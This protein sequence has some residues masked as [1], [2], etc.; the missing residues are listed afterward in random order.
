MPQKAL[1]SKGR[2]PEKLGKKA[3]RVNAKWKTAIQKKGKFAFKSKSA[4]FG[5]KPGQYQAS[6]EMTKEVNEKN[7]MEAARR[8]TPTGGKMLAVTNTP[9]GFQFPISVVDSEL[10]CN[11]SD[12]Y[13]AEAYRFYRLPRLSEDHSFESKDACSTNHNPAVY[14]R[15]HDV[16]VASSAAP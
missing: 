6:I 13:S 4:V 12:G 16:A 14:M 10:S 1:T 3:P 11:P 15:R 8:A 7:E 5:N 2:K 9:Y